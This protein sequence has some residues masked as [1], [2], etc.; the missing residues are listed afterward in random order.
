VIEAVCD[1]SY[2]CGV[3]NPGFGTAVRPFGDAFPVQPV[4]KR[5]YDSAEVRLRKRHANG[6]SLD[7]SYL[8]SR[9]RGNWSGINS[10]DEAVSCLQPNSCL[11][12]DLLYYSYDASGQPS[13]G[14]LA[15]DRPHRLKAL[16]TYDLPWGT[17]IGVSYRIESGRPVSTV[18]R[19][20]T[21]GINF[22]PYGRGDLGRT[23]VL[24]QTDLLIQQHVP[25][26]MDR[27][28]L[29][30]GV[31]VINLFDQMAVMNL[32]T[33]PYR[34]AFNIPAQQFFAGFD[35]A[36]I[37]AATPSMRP[38]PQYRMANNYQPRRSITLQARLTF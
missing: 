1:Q 16:G 31:N 19:M 10:S 25:L 20:R 23:P 17:Q 7:A 38:N 2:S 21:D 36:A 6:W 28:S 33:N 24:S 14:L 9:L 15:T 34:D 30:V 29:R 22:F 5:V 4:A 32:A 12:F 11:A 3:N 18:A 35:P 13:N 8:W 26:G 27:V 37:A